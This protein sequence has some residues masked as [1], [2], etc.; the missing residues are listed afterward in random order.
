M[1]RL[2]LQYII[3]LAL[4][5]LLFL[6]HLNLLLVVVPMSRDGHWFHYVVLALRDLHG[7]RIFFGWFNNACVNIIVWE[8]HTF[9]N[10]F[11]FI[12]FLLLLLL[13]IVFGM[14]ALALLQLHVVIVWLTSR[15]RIFLAVLMNH[16][17]DVCI[18]SQRL[19]QHRPLG[20]NRVLFA[21]WG[22]PRRSIFSIGGLLSRLEVELLELSC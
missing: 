7:C 16:G 5:H 1:D 4:L 18:A 12:V 11:H 14:H 10:F 9:G 22:R 15:Q 3:L 19:A 2:Q 21:P 8:D 17:R 13:R 20:L 6:F